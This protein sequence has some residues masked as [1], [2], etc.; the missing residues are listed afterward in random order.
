LDEAARELVTHGNLRATAVQIDV[1]G[2]DCV[3]VDQYAVAQGIMHERV[4]ANVRLLRRSW[5]PV[6]LESASEVDGLTDVTLA[7]HPARS[8]RSGIRPVRFPTRGRL[9]FPSVST[10]TR[11]SDSH[12]YSTVTLA[13]SFRPE[14]D[15]RCLVRMAQAL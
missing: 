8:K 10:V 2:H 9:S 11:P 15:I 13:A 7:C 6:V 4:H 5:R 1:R 14:E 12:S 3:S